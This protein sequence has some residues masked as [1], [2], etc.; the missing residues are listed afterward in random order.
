MIKISEFQVKDVV[1]VSN[2][3]KMGH[4]ADL[5]INLSTGKIEALIIPGAGRMMGLMRKEN[6]IVIPWRD[7]VKI[8]KDVIL[9]RFEDQTEGQGQLAPPSYH[10][11]AKN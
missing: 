8:G 9:V 7:I 1:N 11:S 4:I 10:N 3:R 6:D 2:G 5:E